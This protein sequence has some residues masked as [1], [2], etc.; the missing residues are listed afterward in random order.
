MKMKSL[1]LVSVM[2]FSSFCFGSNYNANIY[3]SIDGNSQVKDQVESLKTPHDTFDPRNWTDASVKFDRT[4]NQIYLLKD[5]ES[6]ALGTVAVSSEDLKSRGVQK[7]YLVTTTP[8]LQTT[9]QLLDQQTREVC[10]RTALGLDHKLVIT[11][12]FSKITFANSEGS[13]SLNQQV[14]VTKTIFPY[15]CH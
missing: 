10:E 8:D 3:L 7:D 15:I 12:S 5:H 13:I 9:V 11:S 6:F 14:D 2:L 4:S 1:C